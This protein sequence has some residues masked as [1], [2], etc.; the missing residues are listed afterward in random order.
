[1]THGFG[2]IGCGMI[3]RFHAKAVADIE[4]A[5]VAACFDTFPASADR[6][7]EELG[8]KAYHNL[9][10]M[11]ADERVTV[12]TIGTPSGAH[13]DPAVAAAKA[14][15]HV[16][17]EKPLEIT[18]EKCDLIIDECNKA[19]VVVSTIFP[20]R[21]HDSSRKIRKA[22][23]AGRFGRMTVGDAYIKW[24]R[25]QAYYDSGAWRGTW[26][27]DGGGALMNQA[28][29][30]VDLLSWFMGPVAEISAK[31]ALL[32]H[33]GIEVEDVA[34]ASLRFASG[35]LGVIEASTA[36]YPGYLKR[37]ELHGLTGS[38]MMEEEDI[39]KWDFAEET[40]EDAAIRDQM[41]NQTSGGGGAADPAAIGHHGHTHQFQDVVD[42][43][44]QGG[45]PAV[46]GP[47]GRRAVEII[48]AIYKAAETGQTI[49]LPLDG[50]PQ[51][52]ARE[53][54][55]GGL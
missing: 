26:G 11:L 2:I 6:L 35:A 3:S 34:V 44:R 10:E 36:V 50:D 5:E 32:G 14:G 20:S 41:A 1:M 23:D 38:A 13:L 27:L 30:T 53:V 47:E 12:V 24:Y 39:V 19:G 37:V 54:G 21:F 22:I 17:V 33:T 7:G 55:V 16:I 18:L 29:H 45:Q 9:D 40:P 48:L 4:G 28:I 49:K 15:K 46:D 43:I 52:R 25:T 31:T 8:I 42:A 51:L